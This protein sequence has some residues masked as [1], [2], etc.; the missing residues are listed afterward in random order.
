MERG[1][2]STKFVTRV[3]GYLEWILYLKGETECL[4]F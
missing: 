3:P 2:W 4:I 1:M